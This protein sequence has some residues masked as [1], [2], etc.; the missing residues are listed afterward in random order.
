[1]LLRLPELPANA[2][3]GFNAEVFSV[4]TETWPG[5]PRVALGSNMHTQVGS[6][7]LSSAR[8]QITPPVALYSVTKPAPLRIDVTA[9]SG[10]LSPTTLPAAIAFGVAPEG[11]AKMRSCAKVPSPMSFMICTELLDPTIRFTTSSRPSLVK[12]ALA[13]A[14]GTLARF[15]VVLGAGSTIVARTQCNCSLPSVN[16]C[17][18]VR[19]F[20]SPSPFW[21]TQRTDENLLLFG[22]KAPL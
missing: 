21:P 12:S 15:V 17:S 14:N 19:P 9:I 4:P 22:S 1:M 7:P 13:D 11:S 16:T 10:A 8:V 20:G 2:F 5:P 18:K 6:S 3:S